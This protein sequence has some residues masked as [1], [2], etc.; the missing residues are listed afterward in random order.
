MR[1]GL[2]VLAE[3]IE[4]NH[5]PLNPQRIQHTHDGTDH[6]RWPAQIVFDL[7][8]ILVVF[9][10]EVVGHLMNETDG[11]FPVVFRLGL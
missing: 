5:L 10:V 3:V 11:A 4:R 1:L 6:H 9:E 2:P 8:G 7:G